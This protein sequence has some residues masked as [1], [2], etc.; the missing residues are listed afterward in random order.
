MMSRVM[1][2][3]FTSC[4]TEK[5]RPQC[6]AV[7]EHVGRM[8]DTVIMWAVSADNSGITNLWSKMFCT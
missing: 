8:L 6:E 4:S 3:Q 5:A 1:K 7:E 2:V